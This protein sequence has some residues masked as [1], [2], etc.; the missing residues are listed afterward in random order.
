MAGAIPIAIGIK[1]ALVIKFLLTIKRMKLKKLIPELASGIINAGFD[2]NPKPIQS[3]F[4]PNIKSGADIFMISP[5]GSGKSTAIVI[6]VIQQLKKEFEEAPRAIVV[7]STRD[8]A[9]ELEESFKLLGKQTSL[10][11]FVAFD[12]GIIQYQ[13]DE[14]YDGLD[15]LICTP[16]RLTELAN[17]NGVPLTKINLIV[18]DEADEVMSSPYHSIIH[19][20]GDGLKK[21]QFVFSTKAWHQRFDTIEEFLMKNPVYIEPEEDDEEE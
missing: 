7:T 12:Q 14:I 10:R 16:K 5:E 15:I 13:K 8:K 2:V 3:A 17:I 6:G 11:T 4:I 20:I 21:C 1:I 9:F 19:R 18:V